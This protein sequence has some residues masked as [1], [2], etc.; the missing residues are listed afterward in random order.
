MDFLNGLLNPKIHVKILFS[1]H[2]YILKMLNHAFY[3][4]CLFLI[5]MIFLFLRNLTICNL[6]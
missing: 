5:F 6:K 4:F 2:F 3:F 1:M